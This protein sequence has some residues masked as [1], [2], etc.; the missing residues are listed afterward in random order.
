MCFEKPLLW[1]LLETH[2]AFRRLG[3][4]WWRLGDDEPASAGSGEP[5]ILK[6]FAPPGTKQLVEAMNVPTEQDF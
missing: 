4:G 1:W 6:E 5:R 3:E 2:V